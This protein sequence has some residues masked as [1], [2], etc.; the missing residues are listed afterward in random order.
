MGLLS[1]ELQ[2]YPELSARENLEF[3]TGVV[4]PG[5]TGGAGSPRRWPAPD[6][7][8]ERM[9]WLRGSL[10]VCANDWALERALLHSPRL[11]LFDEP[12]TGLDEAAC[13]A[14]VTRLGTLRS[15]RRIVVLATH[16]LDMV[17]AVLDRAVLLWKGRLSELGT[18]G[19]LRERYRAGVAEAARG[20]LV[21]APDNA[22]GRG[23]SGP[24]DLPS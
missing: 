16:D 9:T 2:L 11:V 7:P 23:L 19:S 8:I 18:H 1:H 20:R 5:P 12:F 3:F 15:A 4:R 21:D 6:S 24:G 17:D 22:D 14:L 10:E 13:A